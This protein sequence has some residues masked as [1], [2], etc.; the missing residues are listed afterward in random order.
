MRNRNWMILTFASLLLCG[1]LSGCANTPVQAPSETGTT[2]IAN[3]WADAT[4]AKAAEVLGGTMYNFSTLDKA[5]E[6]YALIVTTDDAVK[7]KSVKP[8]AWIRF[9]KGEDDVSLQMFNSGKLDA[10]QLKGAKAA[11]NG[12][13][14]YIIEPGDGTKSLAWEANGLLYVIG[15]SSVWTGDALVALADGVSA[16]R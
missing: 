12:T 2:Q 16:I 4:P 6:Q 1:I 15:T 7:N 3:P 14:A 9:R 11:V 8:T 5:Y 13:P 10:E